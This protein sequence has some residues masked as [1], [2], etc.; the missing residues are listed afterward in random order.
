MCTRAIGVRPSS[1]ARSEVI[2]ST[3]AAPSLICEE[4]P[5]WM[6]PFS[7]KAGF[8]P[9]SFSGVVPRRR[10]SSV[11]TTRPSGSSTGA[12]W[13][14][15]AP[16]SIAAASLACDCAGELVQLVAGEAPLLRYH[17]RA[18]A[19]VEGDAVAFPHL[20]AAGAAELGVPR[21]RAD[22][23][24]AH[25]LHAA[26]HGHVVLAGDQP[27][28]GEVDRLLG[29]PALPVDG[30]RGDR[31]RPAR[32]EHGHPAHVDALLADLHDAAPDD[33]VHHRG[34]Q[35]V[36]RHQGVQHVGRQVGGVDGGQRAVPLADRGTHRIDNDGVACGHAD[37][38]ESELTVLCP[39]NAITP[40]RW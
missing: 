15:R 1:R 9:A 7:L 24:R 14:F 36:P 31:L 4:L 40:R 20:G 12:I 38:Q 39:F 6:K 10:P 17:L 22:R 35:P 29:G 28:G 3:A 16:A 18:D 34:V 33:V 32:G 23:H 21:G 30:G 2:I 19:L 26:R 37:L 13:D 11:S 8:S 5:A 25:H 27:G